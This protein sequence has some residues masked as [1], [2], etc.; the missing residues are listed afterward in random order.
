MSYTI[1]P[2]GR[3]LI[4]DS[5]GQEVP[6]HY[7][8]NGTSWVPPNDRAPGIAGEIIAKYAGE[9]SEC[10]FQL[11][12]IKAE[13]TADLEPW[14]EWVGLAERNRLIKEVYWTGEWGMDI[15]VEPVL[16]GFGL[17]S[18]SQVKTLPIE[19]EA[20]CRICAA[21]FVFKSREHLADAVARLDSGDSTAGYCDDCREG[22]RL[23]RKRELR[24]M[25]YAEYLRS[26][27][28]QETRAAAME[29]SGH[30]CQLCGQDDPKTVFDVHHN[31]YENL[32]EELP[33]D[34]IVL[35][36]RCH[37]IHHAVQL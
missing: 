19:T 25:P 20:R 5:D 31:T 13:V 36:R 17:N 9:V 2:Q 3:V 24:S 29:R 18:V 16:G 6:R 22:K 21:N 34:L 10:L 28:W 15:P 33:I 30:R 8:W 14:A 32:G 1:D 11:A 26:P 4:L 37:T 23:F 27:E 35:C 12:R 7:I